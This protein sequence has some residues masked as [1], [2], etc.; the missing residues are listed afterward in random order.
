M[1]KLSMPEEVEQYRQRC[2]NNVKEATDFENAEYWFKRALECKSLLSLFYE[3]RMTW[4][5]WA[6]MKQIAELN[7]EE[8]EILK[9]ATV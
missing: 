9:G 7:R 2:F 8:R 5:D 4:N 1:L 6:R 3:K